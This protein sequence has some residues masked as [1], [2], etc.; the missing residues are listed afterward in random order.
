VDRRFVAIVAP[1]FAPG[2]LP[3]N[4]TLPVQLHWSQSE[5][6]EKRCCSPLAARPAAGH[7]HLSVPTSMGPVVSELKIP[8]LVYLHIDANAGSQYIS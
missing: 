3:R 4:L 5:P 8:P 2:T 6:L 7:F 1:T